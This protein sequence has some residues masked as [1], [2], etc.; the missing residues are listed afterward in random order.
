MSDEPDDKDKSDPVPCFFLSY[1]QGDKNSYL[2]KFIRNLRE[3]VGDQVGMDQDKVGFRDEE[4]LHGGDWRTGISLNARRS[5]S[6]VCIYS[7][8]FFSQPG[9]H[10]YC[11]KE[12]AVFLERN[13]ATRDDKGQFRDVRNIF[14]V[15]ASS[16]GGGSRYRGYVQRVLG[17][18]R[19][20]PAGRRQTAGGPDRPRRGGAA[21][22]S[23]Q[24][25]AFEIRVSSA[26]AP[27]W[28]P[29]KDQ[30]NFE[31]LVGDVEFSPESRLDCK[32]QPADPL[33][34][35]FATEVATALATATENQNLPILFVHPECLGNE[36]AR[37]S[38]K[39]V[40]SK[41]WRGGLIVPVDETDAEALASVEKYWPELEAARNKQEPAVIRVA[42]GGVA[43]FQTAA[44]SVAHSV[45]A[46]IQLNGSKR[47]PYAEGKG[48]T[49][50]TY[51]ANKSDS[52]RG[53]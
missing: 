50:I 15:L 19:W 49:E 21:A 45:L 16:V 20:S 3:E 14:P 43:T 28:I 4:N 10:E 34:D 51:I 12:F 42:K 41:D 38:L 46:L 33:I 13:K 48:P 30:M 17:A 11:A 32:I 6:L 35:G 9:A 22:R 31:A 52:A 39:E 7:R 47:H 23:T 36:K 40:L 18:P 44:A 2:D 1:S 53:Q 8:R 5:H 37:A 29:Y 26:D 27:V 24:L 25:L